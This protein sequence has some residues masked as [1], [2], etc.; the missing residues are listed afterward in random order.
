MDLSG[1]TIESLAMQHTQLANLRLDGARIN[2]LDLR[3]STIDGI[4]LDSQALKGLIIDP[5]QSPA[6]VQ[7]LG[8]RVMGV[9]E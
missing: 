9:N 6:V 5:L 1:A 7:S 3:G 2:H 4:M 8:V